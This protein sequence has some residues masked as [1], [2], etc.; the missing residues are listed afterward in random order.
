M[1]GYASAGLGLMVSALTIVPAFAQNG[2]RASLPDTTACP[3]EVADIATCYS[4]K[5]G[6]G[7][8][9]LTAMPK[10]WNGNLI[11]FA[12]GGPGPIPPSAS[13]SMG[14]LARYSIEVKR[15]FAWIASSYRYLGY[16]V[17]QSADDTEDARKFFV[18][19]LGKPKR[20]IVHGASY[21]GLVGAELVE[22]NGGG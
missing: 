5:L 9:L 20:T 11:V 7:A 15:G 18:E 10:D 12:H 22:K 19:R 14:S 8:Y 4:A 3:K 6:T 1:R 13:Y 16:G 2:P 21:G 17:Q